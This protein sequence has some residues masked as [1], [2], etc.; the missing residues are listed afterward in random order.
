MVVVVCA[1][2]TIIT[3]SVN[4]STSTTLVVFQEIIKLV[5]DQLQYLR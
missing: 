4:S 3:V 2:V 1:C 5:T